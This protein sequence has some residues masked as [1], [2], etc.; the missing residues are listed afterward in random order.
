MREVKKRR[1]KTAVAL[2]LCFCVV[3]LTSVFAV[4]ASLDKF[5][6]AD[7]DIQ[8]SKDTKT[9]TQQKESAVSETMPV[10]DSKENT[11][12]TAEKKSVGYVAPVQ[13]KIIKKYSM[14]MPIYSKTL[15]QYMTHPGVDIEVPLNSEVLAA[16]GGTVTKA[17][18]D[19]RYGMMI[20]IDH[21]NGIISTYSNLTD[22]N[23]VELGDVIKQGDVIG[24]VGKT[25]LIESMEP[26]HLHLEMTRNSAY[27]NPD[28][29]IKQ[30]Q[31]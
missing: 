25:A 2:V 24:S 1:D 3:A 22:T 13:G 4:K 15:D 20:E 31:K 9:E 16:A 14:D 19:D 5:K 29:Y 26:A 23:L 11:T 18:E 7:E 28:K 17:T 12:P 30:L 21:G 8:I 27:I 6:T 10:V